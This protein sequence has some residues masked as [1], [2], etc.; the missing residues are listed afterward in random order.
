MSNRTSISGRIPDYK[1]I[2]LNLDDIENG[3]LLD[4]FNR[5]N[6]RYTMQF[7]CGDCCKK[8]SNI[9]FFIVAGDTCGSNSDLAL[10]AI[11]P[12]GECLQI[13]TFCSGQLA[14]KQI[15]SRAG[16]QVNP[17]RGIPI[18]ATKAKIGDHQLTSQLDSSSGKKFPNQTKNLIARGYWPSRRNLPPLLRLIRAFCDDEKLAVE[19]TCGDCLK[20]AININCFEFNRRTDLVSF[21]SEN[22]ECIVD[23]MFCNGKLVDA[24]VYQDIT[25]P[26]EDICSI[27]CGA[28][29]IC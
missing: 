22:G 10:L 16:T 5:N 6:S 21:S 13:E 20:K 18:I 7:E 25:I 17:Q 8:V 19:Y 9:L 24:D 11:P 27:Q 28:V 23:K 15:A 4:D 29:E 2:M 14:D 3:Q 1:D 12:E 26:F